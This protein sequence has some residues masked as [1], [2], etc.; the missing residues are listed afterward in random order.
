M[1]A[2]EEHPYVGA[3]GI[4]YQRQLGASLVKTGQISTEGS[5]EDTL[6]PQKLGICFNREACQMLFIPEYRLIETIVYPERAFLFIAEERVDI[7]KRSALSVR[8]RSDLGNDF[9][10]IQADH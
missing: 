7:D 3:F 10:I 4:G 6:P 1:K 5:A 2:L 9:F 8:E